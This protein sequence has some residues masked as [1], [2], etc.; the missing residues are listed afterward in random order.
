MWNHEFNESHISASH[1]T[2]RKNQETSIASHPFS[3]D[4]VNRAS[5]WLGFHQ[6]AFHH[7]KEKHKARKKHFKMKKTGN[8]GTL[9]SANK[10][11]WIESS[12]AKWCS[13]WLKEEKRWGLW[14]GMKRGKNCV[15]IQDTNHVEPYR[16][17][18]ISSSLHLSSGVSWNALCV[19]IRNHP[20]SSR[21]FS[22]ST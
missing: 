15:N 19:F 9:R 20:L 16:L 2:K 8:W 6:K 13:E 7:C 21:L 5:M 3:R 11:N 18:C 12:D 14:N 10:N 17:Q 22:A 1:R 4:R